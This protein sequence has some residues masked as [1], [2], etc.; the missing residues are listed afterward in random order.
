M[1]RVAERLH[2]LRRESEIIQRRVGRLSTSDHVRLAAIRREIAALS[3]APLV[4][5]PEFVQPVCIYP[6]ETIEVALSRIRKQ[7]GR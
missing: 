4:I 7:F 6:A 3:S 2:A 1:S 5:I